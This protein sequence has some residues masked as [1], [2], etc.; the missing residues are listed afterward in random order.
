MANLIR[1]CW[2]QAPED[3]PDFDY[4]VQELIKESGF[5]V[6]QGDQRIT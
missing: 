3:R 4:I 5:Y 1:A 6:R 2:S